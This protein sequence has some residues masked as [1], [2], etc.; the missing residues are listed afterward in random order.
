MRQP[1]ACGYCLIFICCLLRF[2]TISRKYS[3]QNT[4]NAQNFLRSLLSEFFFHE[5]REKSKLT[6]IVDLFQSA[7]P[8][9]ALMLFGAVTI[10]SLVPGIVG[11]I[12]CAWNR[13]KQR[14]RTPTY[15]L[16]IPIDFKA[17]GIGG[18]DKV[19]RHTLPSYM[20]QSPGIICALAIRS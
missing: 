1:N 10:S 8:Q 17:L 2:C 18:L 9:L 3:V 13:R 19:R 6:S 20:F 5:K 12:Y 16:N 4:Q 11:A 14:K 7:M 15:D